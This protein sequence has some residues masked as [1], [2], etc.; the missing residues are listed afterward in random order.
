MCET[1]RGDMKGQTDQ[2][3]PA[4]IREPNQDPI[5]CIMG[6]NHAMI[7]KIHAQFTL[8]AVVCDICIDIH[9]ADL[10]LSQDVGK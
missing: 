8:G 1:H 5:C 3:P 9:I 2:P 10:C 6:K 7:Q 4:P